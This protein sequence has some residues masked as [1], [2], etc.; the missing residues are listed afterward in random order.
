MR[1][2]RLQVLGAQVQVF[3][4]NAPEFFFVSKVRRRNV[5]VLIYGR[6]VKVQCH[7]CPISL[8]GFTSHAFEEKKIQVK[9]YLKVSQVVKVL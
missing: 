2:D 9:N 1:Q 8:S 3:L 7:N 5:R 4:N 6:I